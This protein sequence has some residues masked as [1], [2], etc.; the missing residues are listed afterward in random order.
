[1]T[2]WFSFVGSVALALS[3]ASS[4]RALE[5]M[6]WDRLPL[7]IP[8]I[9]GQERV[10]FID[11]N[12]RVGVPAP[13]GE[14]LRVQ[15]AA[16]AIYLLAKAPIEPSRLQLQDAESGALILIDVSAA[17]AK[18]NQSLLESVRIVVADN[19][20]TNN[21]PA[22]KGGSEDTSIAPVEIDRSRETP[23]PIILTRYAA[24][25]LY[26]PLRTIEPI[27]TIAPVQIPGD[28][29]LDSLLPMLPV[30]TKAL[31][32]WRLDNLWV[33]AVRLINISFQWIDLDP[34]TL[35]GDFVTAT[36]QHPA[37]APAGATTDTTVVYLVTRGHGLAESLL[38]AISPFNA[39]LNLTPDKAAKPEEESSHAQ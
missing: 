19:L 28:L 10:I 20:M 27:S 37:I 25:N 13:I 36:F 5:V 24:Q 14:Q 18:D 7:P 6:R 38:P 8:L 21:G 35:L 39:S 34:R 4:S 30:R 17:P 29:P 22:S 31:A 1:M 11:R 2:R 23:L 33:T 15:S 12:V 3:F 26:A 32:A 9:V 16:G